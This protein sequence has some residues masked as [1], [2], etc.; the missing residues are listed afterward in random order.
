[1][2]QGD[3]LSPLLLNFASEYA[4][5][6]VQENDEG[7]ELIGIHKLLVPADVVNTIILG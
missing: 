2:K 1:L 6:K 3:A 7:L 4:I 5:S